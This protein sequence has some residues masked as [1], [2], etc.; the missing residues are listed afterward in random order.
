MRRMLECIPD[1]LYTS[2]GVVSGS[3]ACQLWQP[4]CRL[5]ADAFVGATPH[6]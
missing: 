3:I 1:N 2:L 5:V 6:T 4:C